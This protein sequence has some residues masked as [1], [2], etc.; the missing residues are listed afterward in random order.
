MSQMPKHFMCSSRLV[1]MWHCHTDI[2]MLI[3]LQEAHPKLSSAPACVLMV[4]LHVCSL[5]DFPWTSPAQ[6]SHVLSTSF[7][8]WKLAIIVYMHVASQLSLLY[9]KAMNEVRTEVA[10]DALLPWTGTY[11]CAQC[12]Q[13]NMP[14]K[15]PM[16]LYMVCGL[17]YSS[18]P[19]FT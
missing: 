15:L 17:A 16:E 11:S 19:P 1:D 5:H 9:T 13:A 12:V 3:L 4:A 18:L 10:L 7:M 14:G 2:H 6:H 8:I